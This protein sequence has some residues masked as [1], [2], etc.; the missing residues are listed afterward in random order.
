M[1][2]SVLSLLLLILFVF[3]SKRKSVSLIFIGIVLSST[4][5]GILVCNIPDI[6]E[7]I[8]CVNL[9]FL[10]LLISVFASSFI[11]YRTYSFKNIDI[12]NKQKIE[13]L[14]RV[15]LCVCLFSCFINTSVCVIVWSIIDNFNDFKQNTEFAT[16]FMYSNL[17]F[18]HFY[19]SLSALFSCFSYFAIGFHFYYLIYSNYK[20]AILFL[21]A[22]LAIILEGLILF[23][24]SSIVHFIL[25]YL[26]YLFL[27]YNCFNVKIKQN[28]TKICTLFFI[29]LISIMSI[30]SINRFD[31][32]ALFDIPEKS[33]IQNDLWY[34]IFDYYSQW[35][36]NGF[37]VM[38][39][40]SFITLNGELSDR[41][42][43]IITS[44][45]NPPSE[46]EIR[47]R[48]WPN[49]W[50]KFNGAFAIMLYDLGYIGSFI[51]AFFFRCIVKSFEPKNGVINIYTL[52]NFGLFITL[53]IMSVFGY[54]LEVFSFNC[55]ILVS[56]FIWIF[57]KYNIK[58]R[59]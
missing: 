50:W 57:L 34:S 56:I 43:D 58:L 55:A 23:S 29:F 40:Y 32:K 20:K 44:L 27:C 14:S 24:R 26:S 37:D 45:G 7:P 8:D 25:L 15:V 51:L 28:V 41:L 52:L 6:S 54:F 1:L 16:E 22:S 12:V 46:I 30:I 3:Y 39:N 47:E 59:L 42:I 31:G 10:I 4:L 33:V 9:L 17:P 21:I 18:S 19:L 2:V 5:S 53:P 11:N 36:K 13:I 48:I 49:H 38:R 35:L